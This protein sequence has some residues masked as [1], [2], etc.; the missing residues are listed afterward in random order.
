M[1]ERWAV[2]DTHRNLKQHHGA[3]HF[4]VWSPGAVEG[5]FQLVYLS[6]A[7]ASLERAHRRDQ[8]ED[9]TWEHLHRDAIH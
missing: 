9:C 1:R 3:E 8:E 6:G 2:E 4:H 5:H 7:V